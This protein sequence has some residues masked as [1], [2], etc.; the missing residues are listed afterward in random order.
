MWNDWSFYGVR[1]A[2]GL[3]EAGFFPGVL[4][5]L[6][7]WFPARYRGRMVGLFMSAGVFAQILGPPLG[8]LLMRLDGCSASPDGSG[9]SSW[10]QCRRW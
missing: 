7:W 3:A 6:T 1:F 9:C 10:R 4:I 8:G 5:Y 2:L